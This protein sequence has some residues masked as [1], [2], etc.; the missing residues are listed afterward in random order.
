MRPIKDAPAGVQSG[1][2]QDS[3][4]D[5][6]QRR[7]ILHQPVTSTDAE[8]ETVL[9]LADRLTRL[10]LSQE[11]NIRQPLRTRL[12]AQAKRQAQWGWPWQFLVG[13]RLQPLVAL[14]STG[15]LLLI[16]A[17]FSPLGGWTAGR[18]QHALFATAGATVRWQTEQPARMVADSTDPGEAAL[19]VAFADMRNPAPAGASIA[20]YDPAPQTTPSILAAGRGTD[21]PT[22]APVPAP[23]E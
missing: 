3:I 19:L 5:D 12:V 21:L 14:V 9:D 20:G 13:W 10:N 8:Q 17:A 4:L 2:V 16:A 11:S 1:T 6:T 15:V 23:P 18:Y 7:Q 22:P